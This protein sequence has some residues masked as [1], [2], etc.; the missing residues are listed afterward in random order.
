MSIPHRAVRF[1]AILSAAVSFTS[2]V[3]V[4][5]AHAQAE[6]EGVSAETFQPSTSVHSLFELVLPEPKEHLRWSVGGLVHYAHAPVRRERRLPGSPGVIDRADAVGMRVTADLTAALGLFDFLEVG[7]GVPLIAYQNGE[8]AVPGGGIQPAGVG[9]PRLEVKGRLLD[10]GAVDLGLGVVA[11]FP[12]GHY[13]SSGEDLLG[14]TAPTVEPRV[15]FSAEAGPLILAANAGFLARGPAEMG[16]YRQDHALTWNAGAAWDVRDFAEPGGVRVALETNGQAGI[17]FSTL[18]ETP[19]EAIAGVKLRTRDDLILSAGG[20][21]GVSNAVGT[22]AFRVF[23]GVGYDSV[24]RSC[25]AGP[26]D[27]D[28]FE[29]DDKCVDPDNDRDGILDEDD[30]CPDAAEDFDEVEDEDGCPD[31]D[32]DGDAIPDALDECPMIPEDADD[33]ED[34][35]GCPEE[36]PGKPTV[37]ITD[38][39]LLV[40]SKIYFDYDKATIKRVSHP[41]L[42]AVAEALTSNEYIRLV[43]VEGHTD[44]EGTEDYNMELSV[45]RARAVVEYLVGKGVAKERLTYKGYGFTAP[46]A[47]NRTEEGRAINRR[48]EFT[49]LEKE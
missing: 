39:Q 1:A 47:S 6:G 8:G 7:L 2:T 25:P 10:A 9:D 41:I 21:A 24:L 37:S 12:A 20:G 28:G 33:Y 19:M 22:P 30:E 45:S 11:T 15:L 42:D 35:D 14:S 17:G 5:A 23:V 18:R 46:K 34:E 13:L 40:S 38:T 4:P 32:N 29:D 3:C 16:A 49:I 26:E 48:V 43:R 36:G 44:N 31:R 27:V